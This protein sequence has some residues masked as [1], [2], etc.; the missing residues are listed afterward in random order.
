VSDLS[1][2]VAAFQTNHWVLTAVTPLWLW[3]L[4]QWV[5]LTVAIATGAQMWTPF[6]APVLRSAELGAY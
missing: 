6:I 2:A 4:Q 1:D 5:A 3:M